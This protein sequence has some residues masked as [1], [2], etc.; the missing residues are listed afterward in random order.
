MSVTDWLLVAVIVVT[1]IAFIERFVMIAA[2]VIVLI[3]L[4]LTWVVSGILG[5][6][7]T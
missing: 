1:M 3:L 7:G 6:R 2:S 5:K 4:L